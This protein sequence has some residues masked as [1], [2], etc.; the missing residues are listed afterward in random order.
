M[1]PRSTHHHVG[2]PAHSSKVQEDS[3]DAARFC[4]ESPLLGVS[5]RAA[6]TPTAKPNRAAAPGGAISLPSRQHSLVR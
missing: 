5:D 2:D 1:A 6:P 4:A 3:Q